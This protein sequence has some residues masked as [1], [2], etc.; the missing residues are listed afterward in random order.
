[1]MLHVVYEVLDERLAR[2]H[3]AAATLTKRVYFRFSSDS[4]CI[5]ASCS[6]IDPAVIRNGF[7]AVIIAEQWPAKR[8]SAHL[9]EKFRT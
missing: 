7:R 8:T 3:H 9:Y 5:Q 6:G 1:M 2:H 4:S